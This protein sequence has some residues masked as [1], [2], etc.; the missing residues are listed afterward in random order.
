ALTEVRRRGRVRGRRCAGETRPPRAAHARW[1]AAERAGAGGG[2]PPS[3]AGVGRIFP[4]GCGGE[5]GG[6]RR[7]LPE[8][9]RRWQGWL[10]LSPSPWWG[11]VRGGG[12]EFLRKRRHRN[13][14]ALPPPPA[15]P[16]KGEG[17]APNAGRGSAPSV[18]RRQWPNRESY[19]SNSSTSNP[20]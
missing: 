5:G 18:R 3:R 10:G 15:P 7:G 16:H 11:G 6:V 4:E 2:A 19:P 8:V 20:T 13:T 14:A 17:S 12:P 1:R 9:G